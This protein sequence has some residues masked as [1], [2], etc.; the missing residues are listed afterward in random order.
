M[1][2]V[3]KKKTTKK[4]KTEEEIKTIVETTKGLISKRRRVLLPAIAIL[5]A[6]IIV[7]G[8]IF[9]YRSSQMKRVVTLEYDAYKT[10]YSLYQ[11][12]PISQTDRYEQALERFKKAYSV[13]KTPVSLFYISSCYYGLGKY[14]EALKALKELNE[15]FPDDENFVPLSYYKMAMISL[16]KGEREEALKY[17][18]TLYNYKTGSFKDLALLEMAR[19]LE[20]MDRKEESLK[21]YEELAKNFPNSPFINEARAKLSQKG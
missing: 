7:I 5:S 2:K 11:R 21:R 12:Q 3:I 10:F 13:R 6:L 16:K 19:I 15:R 1:P 17:L 18:E 8:G 9:I 14:D 20:G 4:P